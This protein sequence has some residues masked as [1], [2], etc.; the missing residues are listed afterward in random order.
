MK[1]AA[2]NRSH[3]LLTLYLYACY[4]VIINLGDSDQLMKKK[5]KVEIKS[6]VAVNLS[7]KRLA[8]IGCPCKQNNWFDHN[9]INRGYVYASYRNTSEQPSRGMHMYAH[10]HELR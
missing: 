9:V 1:N 10:I 6:D 2:H 3:N 4:I 7:G 5:S 8:S